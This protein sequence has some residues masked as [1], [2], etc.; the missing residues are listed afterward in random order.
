MFTSARSRLDQSDSVTTRCFNKIFV[1]MGK[2][3]DK[4]KQGLGELKTSEKTNR[5]L[6]A[7]Q[8]RMLQ[9]LG[10]VRNQNVNKTN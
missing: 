10:E 1:K 4:K 5:K 9:K 7:K 3:K 6:V 2:K 8:K